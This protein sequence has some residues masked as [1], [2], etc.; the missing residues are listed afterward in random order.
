MYW[1]TTI[2]GLVGLSTVVNA[3]LDDHNEID[4]CPVGYAM[5]TY[6]VTTTFVENSTT[7]VNEWATSLPRANDGHA[8]ST[9]ATVSALFS[10]TPSVDETNENAS[11]S[12]PTSAVTSLLPSVK[13]ESSPPISPTPLAGGVLHGQATSYEGGDVDGTCMFSTADYTLP[14]GIY[15]AALS[16]DNWDNAALCGACLSVV[17]PGGKSVKIMIINQC[18]GT[19]GLN[20]VDLLPSAFQQLAD[21]KVGRINV[22]WEVVKCGITSPL[23]LKTKSGSS[24]YWFSIQVV[25]SNVPVRSLEVSI[26]GGKTWQPLS[27]QEYNFFQ[28]PSGFGVDIVDV[29]VTSVTGETIVVNNVNSASETRT[30]ATSNFH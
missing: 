15:G 20:N 18:P 10:S 22:E 12:A 13:V 6:V 8:T 26:D 29:R 1:K 2:A 19:C 21:L 28:N 23:F 7:A 17:G 4:N 9:Q 14:A 27:R 30:D 24:K 16:V 3:G 5:T 25:N 11:G